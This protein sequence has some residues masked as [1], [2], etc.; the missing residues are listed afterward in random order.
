MRGVHKVRRVRKVHNVH[1][2]HH[3]HNVHNVHQV[4][5]VR[6]LLCLMDRRRRDDVGVRSVQQADIRNAADGHIV[7]VDVAGKLAILVGEIA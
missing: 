7:I 6:S 4:H 2:M 1:N 3:V 5:E